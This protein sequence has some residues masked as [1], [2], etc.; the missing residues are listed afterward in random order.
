M[1]RKQ[2]RTGGVQAKPVAPVSKA[3]EKFGPATS[4]PVRADGTGNLALGR[5]R[6]PLYRLTKSD[7]L[8]LSF[9]FTP[10]FNQTVTIQP[11]GFITLRDA[12]HLMAEGQTAPETQ[13]A[14]I[15]IYSKT[16]HDPR[17]TVAVKD[18]EHPYFVVSG[19]VARPVNTNCMGAKR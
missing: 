9:L 6:R 13:Q 5:E 1:P 14:I 2:D 7:V 11:D 4:Q 19:E 18:F 8:E 3:P 16:L 12:G 17:A 10:E 15:E